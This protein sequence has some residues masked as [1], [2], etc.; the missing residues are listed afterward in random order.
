MYYLRKKK[1]DKSLPLFDK[2]GIKVKK[3][4]DLKAKLDKV[5]S[6]YIRLRDSRDFEY[7]HFRCISCGEIKPFKMADCGHFHSRRHLS[8]RWDERNCYA[9]CSACNRFKSDHLIGFQESLLKRIGQQ[10]FDLLAWKSSQTMRYTDFEL[11]ELIKYY[12]DQIY[13]MKK[14]IS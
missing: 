10:T 14:G 7:R 9:E 2:A 13:Q 11:K 3:K 1:K 4:T 5:F 8:T 6:L 12:Q